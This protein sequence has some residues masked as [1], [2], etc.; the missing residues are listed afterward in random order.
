MAHESPRSI[1]R[2][3]SGT[4]PRFAIRRARRHRPVR[5]RRTCDCRSRSGRDPVRPSARGSGHAGAVRLG[6]IAP[7]RA[8]ANRCRPDVERSRLSDA[9]GGAPLAARRPVRTHVSSRGDASPATPLSVGAVPA[10][11]AQRAATR[12]PL[13][14]AGPPVRAIAPKS[15]AIA[16][17]TKR[18]LGGPRSRTPVRRRRPTTGSR[19]DRRRAPRFWLRLQDSNLRPGG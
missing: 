4:R 6:G 17:E 19:R 7:G 5:S 11:I 9:V 15:A 14:L 18:A 12:R 3:P 2:R 16:V 10:A 1:R 13:S 8:G